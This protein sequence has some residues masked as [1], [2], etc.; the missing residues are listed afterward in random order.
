MERDDEL[1]VEAPVCGDPEFPALGSVLLL[2]GLTMEIVEV[3]G[4]GVAVLLVGDSTVVDVEVEG[5]VC[6][7]V[8]VVEVV[9]CLV[10]GT[11]LVTLTTKERVRRRLL[12]ASKQ[13]L[14]ILIGNRAYSSR[15]VPIYRKK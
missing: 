1:L 13:A 7:E 3:V 8:G 2:L 10:V 4:V 11:A 6:L 12:E 15:S 9:V 5:G 14:T